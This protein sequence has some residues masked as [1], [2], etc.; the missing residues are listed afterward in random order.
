VKRVSY[1]PASGS[2]LDL[3]LSAAILCLGIVLAFAVVDILAM[4]ALS[5]P[6]FST[7]ACL[8]D[9]ERLMKT[10]AQVPVMNTVL[11]GRAFLDYIFALLYGLILISTYVHG[12]REWRSSPRLRA[13]AL[14]LLVALAAAASLANI[15]ED[16]RWLTW[17][18]N[19][20]NY[21]AAEIAVLVQLKF[22]LISLNLAAWTFLAYRH[23][24]AF[25]T[26]WL[27]EKERDV[28]KAGR[29]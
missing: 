1:P 13:T 4:Q 29:Y 9:V 22:I 21:T 2:S 16:V 11:V 19:S 14:V 10:A 8:P 6:C 3:H 27:K 7:S 15:V 25:H 12:T 24:P 5:A 23:W 28:V 20:E 17:S 26:R 18:Q